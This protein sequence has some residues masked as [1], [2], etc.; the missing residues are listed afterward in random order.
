MDL[1]KTGMRTW[2]HLTQ[3]RV[4]WLALVD[5]VMNLWGPTKAMEYKLYN[6]NPVLSDTELRNMGNEK[7]RGRE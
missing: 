6:K 1:A 3:I 2:I 4:R 7:E 5:T